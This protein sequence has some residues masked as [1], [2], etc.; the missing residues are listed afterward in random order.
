MEPPAD[1]D[2][3]SSLLGKLSCLLL[4]ECDHVFN[5]WL[6]CI[7]W[8]NFLVL[9]KINVTS[10]TP[11]PIEF[12]L[13]VAR[14]KR[15]NIRSK[16]IY[17]GISLSITVNT[18]LAIHALL[19]TRLMSPKLTSCLLHHNSGY[20]QPWYQVVFLACPTSKLWIR[21]GIQLTIRPFTALL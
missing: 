20:L 6:S 10:W 5:M 18:W 12:L 15:V 8:K 7:I 11:P 21:L 14:L 1:V 13:K 17:T 16:I 2:G 9:Y 4:A 3:P 19:Y